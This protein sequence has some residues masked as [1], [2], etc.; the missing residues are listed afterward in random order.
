MVKSAFLSLFILGWIHLVS[1]Q[2]LAF[3]GAE[4]GGKYTAGGRGGRVL[5]VDN[6]NDR[7]PG[8]L[9]KAVEAAHPERHAGPEEEIRNPKHEIRNRVDR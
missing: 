6:L 9:R 8:S 3:P 2:P 1:G 5:F 4:G 7:G